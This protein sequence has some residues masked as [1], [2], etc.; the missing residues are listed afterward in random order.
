MDRCEKHI[1]SS[2]W[3]RKAKSYN[4]EEIQISTLKE[5]IKQ[6]EHEK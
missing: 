5:I 4:F 1:E 3:R 6:I 2:N